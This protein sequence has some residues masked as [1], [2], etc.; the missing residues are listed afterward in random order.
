MRLVTLA[1]APRK[2]GARPVLGRDRAH[3]ERANVVTAG[4]RRSLDD[5]APREHSIASEE[6][7]DMPAAVD[8]RDMEGV[9]EAVETQGASVRDHMAPIDEAPPEAPLALAELI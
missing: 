6:R 5:F 2:I 7:R 1:F 8:R 3:P 4:Q 9:G